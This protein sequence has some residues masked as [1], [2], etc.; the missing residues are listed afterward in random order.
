MPLRVSIQVMWARQH[1]GTVRVHVGNGQRCA[2]PARACQG[3]G[4]A[5]AMVWSRG[6]TRRTAEVG[7][8]AV[9]GYMRQHAGRE[10][11]DPG[12]RLACPGGA[13]TL[14]RPTSRTGR[15]RS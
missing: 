13:V 6:L 8:C 1:Q 10:I 5:W 3:Q 14:V 4:V 12:I 11:R 9:R 15:A 2:V 7:A